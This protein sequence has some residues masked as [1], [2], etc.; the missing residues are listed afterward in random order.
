MSKLSIK[1]KEFSDMLINKQ[2]EKYGVTVEDIK[3]LPEHKVEGELWCLHYT[4]DS[5]EE[6]E[7]WKKFCI[8]A[9]MKSKENKSKEGAVEWFNWFNLSYGL[10]HNY[11]L[12][13]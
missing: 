9:I 12:D 7:N 1:S 2:L 10:K 5:K 4:F 6:F 13:K 8:N 3:K 11:E